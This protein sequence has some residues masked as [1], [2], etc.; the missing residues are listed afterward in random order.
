MRGREGERDEGQ[1]ARGREGER[2]RG[3]EGE[4]ARGR[5]G[6]RARGRVAQTNALEKHRP[7]TGRNLR[8]FNLGNP[9]TGIFR[10]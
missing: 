6:E 8:C 1:R 7:F 10:T 4:R 5:E 9:D 3:R 2:A